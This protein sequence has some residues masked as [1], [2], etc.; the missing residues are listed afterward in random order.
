MTNVDVANNAAIAVGKIS[1]LGKWATKNAIL[2]GDL[3]ASISA[4][5]I[6][7]LGSLAAKN[8]V[9]ETEIAGTIQ[10]TKISGLG[11]LAA[12]NSISQTDI[13]GPIPSTKVSGLGSMSAQESKSVTITGGSISGIDVR[14]EFFDTQAQAISATGFAPLNWD[15]NR[16]LD[17]EFRHTAGSPSVTILGGGPG[18]R[19]EIMARISTQVSDD[20]MPGNTQLRFALNTGAGF[21]EIR[22]TRAFVPNSGAVA[23]NATTVIFATLE[24]PPVGSQIQVE[25]QLASAASAVTTVPDGITL[26]IK[27]VK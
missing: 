3:P 26:I 9:S 7:G 25:A 11:A 1:G 18:T 5:K 20:L 17:S 24:S 22:G 14:A 6:T 15:T 13:V 21:S 27:K 12:K 23:G 2:E 16:I 8:S 19:Y 4:T 10:S